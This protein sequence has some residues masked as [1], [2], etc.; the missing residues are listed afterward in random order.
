MDPDICDADVDESQHLPV[1]TAAAEQSPPQAALTVGGGFSFVFEYDLNDLM[2]YAVPAS[3][4]RLG[5]E[6]NLYE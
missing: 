4:R 6:R 1:L 3:P 5:S 2:D